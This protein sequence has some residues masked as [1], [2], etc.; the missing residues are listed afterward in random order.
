MN[1]IFTDPTK[2][3]T[4]SPAADALTT[5]LASI[6]NENGEP[7]YANVETAIDALKHSQ[8]F[9]PSLKS[10][11]TEQEAEI[12]RLRA[13]VAKQEG[14]QE[15]LERFT[16]QPQAQQEEQNVTPS[17]TLGQADVESLVQNMFQAQ[18]QQTM[19]EKNLAQVQNSLAA[20]YGDKASDH[21]ASKAAALNTTREALLEMAKTNPTMALTLLGGSKQPT[22][23]PSYGGTN[24]TGFSTPAITE[25]TRPAESLMTGARGSDVKDFMAKIKAEVY[26]EHGITN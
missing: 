22:T 17:A 12:S 7:K 11:M 24:T 15:V 6:V 25:L 13:Q 19:A 14:V 16:K 9:I 8:E 26:R 1:N 2:D 18:A 5:K 10:Q 20:Q 23:A 21:I 4:A 3:Q